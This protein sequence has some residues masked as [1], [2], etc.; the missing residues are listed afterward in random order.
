MSN[1]LELELEVLCHIFS[2]PTLLDATDGLSSEIFSSDK[3]RKIF[4]AVSDIWEDDG[5]ES[6]NEAIVAD[7]V[8]LPISEITKITA[9]AYAI[10]AENFHLLIRELRGK[11]LSGQLYRLTHAEVERYSKTGI[12]EWDPTKTGE[13]RRLFEEL[14]GLKQCEAGVTRPTTL[15]LSE[16]R[17]Q[18]VPWLWRNFIPRGRATLLSGDPGSAKTWFALDITARLSRGL[19]WADGTQGNGPANIYYMTVEDDARDTIRPRIDSLGGDPSRIAIYNSENPLHVDLSTE[20]GRQRIEREIVNVGNVKLVV[21]DPIADFSG[22]VNPNAAEDVRALLTPLIRMA[23]RRDFALMMIGHLN[24]AQ[25][26]SAIYRA[27][28]ST[29]GWLGKCRASFMIIRNKDERALRHVIAIKANLA[30]Q[31]PPQLE[32]RINDGRLDIGIST[33]EID[34]EDQLGVQQ[35]GPDPRERD[36]AVAWLEEFFMGKYELP[37]TD[38]EEAARANGISESTL[39][40]AKKQAGYRSLKRTESGGKALWVWAR[41]PS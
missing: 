28:G 9:G 18:A 20:P 22:D 25:T 40:R 6:I 35:H 8:K 16:I 10:S 26:M 38:I 5:P 21:I 19:Q 36:E 34:P 32:F 31:D 29:S 13:I 27:G 37:A 7:R 12:W 15:L 11:S 39:R 17:A 33:H 3:N 14:D 4:E 24:K 1:A 41:G 23:A 2:Q 30:P